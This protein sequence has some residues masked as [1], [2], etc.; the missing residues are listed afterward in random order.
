MKSGFFDDFSNYGT[1]HR[2]TDDGITQWHP[3]FL[4]L[5]KLIEQ[6]SHEYRRFCQKQKPKNKNQNQV[7]S[8]SPWGC[9]F[10]PYLTSFFFFFFFFLFFPFLSLSLFY[11]LS[12]F[13]YYPS[14]LPLFSSLLTFF[15][16]LSLF[17]L[18]FPFFFFLYFALSLE[19]NPWNIS[20]INSPSLVFATT[21]N[22]P[23]HSLTSLNT[24]LSLCHH[25]LHSRYQLIRSSTISHYFLTSFFAL[26]LEHKS[27][28]Q[29]T[30]QP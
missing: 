24:S 11:P 15:F 14:F 20:H 6:C 23:H 1:Y 26:S 28:K 21:V 5:A 12:F 27:Y 4:S 30:Q 22:S 2:L 18:F 8:K 16:F 29:S 3:A 9:R 7:K 17:S 25:S 13:F 10:L 19:H